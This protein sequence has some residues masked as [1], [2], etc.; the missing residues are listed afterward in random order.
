[1]FPNMI[2]M[3]MPSPEHLYCLENWAIRHGICSQLRARTESDVKGGMV[4]GDEA[5]LVWEVSLAVSRIERYRR[6]GQV[7]LTVRSTNRN[8]IMQ[9]RILSRI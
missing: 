6:F 2:G 7:S 4:Y 9:L 3:P 8:Y 5:G 1:M